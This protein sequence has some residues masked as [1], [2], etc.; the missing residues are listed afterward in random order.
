MKFIWLKDQ[1]YSSQRELYRINLE[2]SL[3]LQ[4]RLI[5]IREDEELLDDLDAVVLIVNPGTGKVQVDKNT[6]EPL[7]TLL[8][9]KVNLISVPLIGVKKLG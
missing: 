3:Q 1:N 2:Y 4:I 5:I 9:Q 7:Y 8:S 6:P